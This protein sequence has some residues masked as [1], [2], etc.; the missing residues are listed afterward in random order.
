MVVVQPAEHLGEGRSGGSP[1][2]PGPGEE[3]ERLFELYGDEAG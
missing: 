3:R 2:S 1:D